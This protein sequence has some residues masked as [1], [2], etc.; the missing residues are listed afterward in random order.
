[1][2]GEGQNRT[3]YLLNKCRDTH[4][5]DL[6]L[7]LYIRVYG[8]APDN[9]A[10]SQTFLCTCVYFYK[11]GAKKNKVNWAAAA[12]Q[13]T[14]ERQ[15]HAGLNPLKL[16]PPA[17]REQLFSIL[18]EIR[19]YFQREGG[20]EPAQSAKSDERHAEL[21]EGGVGNSGGRDAG[22]HDVGVENSGGNK[23]E[24]LLEAVK[25]KT[26]QVN[27]QA[28]RIAQLRGTLKELEGK[29]FD[30]EAKDKRLNS[31]KDFLRKKSKELGVAGSIEEKAG[32]DKE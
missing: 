9:K 4:A 16:G 26:R 32:V 11:D 29:I 20:V 12:A 10:F 25:E 19:A 5:R 21:Q 15:A 1:M 3:R 2:P 24:E 7:S 17:L 28:K 31:V 22:P 6:Y 30:W 27:D 14:E 18:K 8:D 23:L 13:L